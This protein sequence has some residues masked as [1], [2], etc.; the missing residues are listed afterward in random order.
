E[1]LPFRETALAQGI[2]V[3]IGRRYPAAD[4]NNVMQLFS[5]RFTEDH[6]P[7][8]QT[9]A[10][11]AASGK[12]NAVQFELGVGLRW[13]GVERERFVATF[14]R[15]LGKPTPAAQ[16]EDCDFSTLIFSSRVPDHPSGLNGTPIPLR[17]AS[18]PVRLGL[19]FHDPVSGLGLMGG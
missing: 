14:C 16:D 10:R 18:E 19:H 8:I 9:L 17:H 13:P 4:K 6:S 15:T 1:L 7:L 5:S 11:L 12:I 3:A 2:D